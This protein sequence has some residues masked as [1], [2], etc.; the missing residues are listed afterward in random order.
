MGL[1]YCCEHLQDHTMEMQQFDDSLDSYLLI[2][3]NLGE[4]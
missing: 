1:P 2:R 4:N 3:S